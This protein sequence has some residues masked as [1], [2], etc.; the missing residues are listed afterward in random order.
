VFS[1]PGGRPGRPLWCFCGA[2]AAVAVLA[3]AAAAQAVEG[4]RLRRTPHFLI[5][6]VEGSHAARDVEQIA[7]DLELLYAEVLAPLGL[8]PLQVIY[9]LY[10][11]VER[12]RDA[13]W[14]FATLGSGDLV[15]AW[16]TI[17]TGDFRALTPYTITRAVVSHG[18]PRAIPLL[19]WGFGEALGDRVAGVDAHAH[20]KAALDAGLAM[21]ALR[22]ILAPS[23]FGEALPMSY[24]TAVSFMAYLIERFGIPQT[25]AFVD[26]VAY[27]YFDFPDLFVAHFGVPLDQV[28]RA[29]RARVEAARA[30]RRIDASTYLAATR[31]VYRITLAG[32]PGRRMLLA[33][34]A[35]VVSEALAA[36]EPLRR[37]N[38]E[39]ARRSM[40]IARR[41]SE[42]AER[43]ERR[44]GTLLRGA[45]ALIVLA[46]VALAVGWLLWPAV[47]ARRA[48]GRG[49]R[50]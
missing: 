2:L 11:S 20:L 13:W 6:T 50:R 17:Y 8:P 41:A 3:S 31:F 35:V 28:E 12:F 43:E 37:L 45:V 26:R 40:Q 49:G 18:Y 7:A 10:P 48:G 46:P 16:G 47:R 19:R 24:P 42:R 30:S 14:Y 9:P 27:R 21:P 44:A 1:L 22:R 23:D 39:A 5:Y 34:G 4:W 36:V 38:L 29:W 32:T 33:D 25:G 15:H